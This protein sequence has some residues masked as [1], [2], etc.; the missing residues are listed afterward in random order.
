MIILFLFVKLGYSQTTPFK[1]AIVP[2]EIEELGG[3]QS[4]AWR[5]HGGK[6]LIIGGR[7]LV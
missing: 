3:L 6:W 1:V 4:F 5:Q 7:L 2:I